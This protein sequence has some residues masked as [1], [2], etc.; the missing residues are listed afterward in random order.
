MRTKFKFISLFLLISVLAGAGAFYWAEYRKLEQVDTYVRAWQA[1]MADYLTFDYAAIS[2]RLGP[3]TVT[4]EEVYVTYPVL[5]SVDKLSISPLPE[6]KTIEKMHITAEGLNFT[7]P[8]LTGDSPWYGN[9]DLDYVYEPA[10]QQLDLLIAADF[11]RFFQGRVQTT[12]LE[13]VPNVDIVFTYPHIL[14]ATLNV[15]LRN[16]GM[17]QQAGLGQMSDEA[18]LNFLTELASNTQRQAMAD[19]WTSQAPLTINFYPEHPVP[20]FRLLENE[21]LFWQHPAVVMGQ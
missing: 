16:Q 21:R 20:I 14:L 5:M 17:L 12:L 1:R 18:L 2:T 7:L 10:R 15:Q 3:N 8:F 9:V 11:P 4:L 13:I 19:F 6:D